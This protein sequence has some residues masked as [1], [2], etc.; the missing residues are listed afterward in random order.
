MCSSDL[1]YTHECDYTPGLAT[2][3]N[4]K[5]ATKIC[6]SYNETISRFSSEIQNKCVVTGNPVRPVFYKENIQIGLNFLG[7]PLIHAKPLLL[8]QGGSLG[9]KQINTLIVENLSWL[10]EKFIVVHQMGEAFAKE[11]PELFESADENYKPFDFIHSQMPDVLHACDVVISRSGANSIW[12]CAVC[13]KPMI[14]IPLVGNGTRGDQLDNAKY[15]EERGAAIVL[16][17]EEANAENLKNALTLFLQASN[18]K[19]YSEHCKELS[20]GKMPASTIAQMILE[21]CKK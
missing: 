19:N 14:L 7:V 2:K 13:A 17:G 6:V 20:Q 21:G 1:Y 9:A 16:A 11:H 18:R 8:I 3:L 5:S 15:F 12:E 10:K 4:S